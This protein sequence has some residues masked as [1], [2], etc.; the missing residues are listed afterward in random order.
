MAKENVLISSM[1]LSY[2]LQRNLDISARFCCYSSFVEPRLGT[3]GVAHAS[4]DL[5]SAIA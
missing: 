1:L 5:S 2:I 4:E 3:V